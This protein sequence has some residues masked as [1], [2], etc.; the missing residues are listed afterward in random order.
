VDHFLLRDFPDI[1]D[2]QGSQDFGIGLTDGLM[3]QL[4]SGLGEYA[5]GSL[6]TE[7]NFWDFFGS[8]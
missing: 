1:P 3:D 5:W 2:N 8:N 6:N 4:E 7:G